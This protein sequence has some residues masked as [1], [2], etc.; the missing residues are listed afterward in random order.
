M[1]KNK[2]FEN[3]ILS[4]EKTFDKVSYTK[5]YDLIL[6]SEIDNINFSLI[7]SFFENKY[8]KDFKPRITVY[9]KKDGELFDGI[10]T[11]EFRY[12]KKI[13]SDIIDFIITEISEIKLNILNEI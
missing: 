8:N 10:K 2:F 6:S 1:N 9:F 11:E 13:I 7:I 5:A 12:N 3:L 4:F